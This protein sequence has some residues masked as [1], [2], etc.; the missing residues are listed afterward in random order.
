VAI[1]VG[2]F[3]SL[4]DIT[5]QLTRSGMIAEDAGIKV[6]NVHNGLPK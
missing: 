2:A 3:I 6:Q 5:G 1:G 4:D